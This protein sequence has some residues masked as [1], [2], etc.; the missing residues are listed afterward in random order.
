MA[1]AL[2]PDRRS[3]TSPAHAIEI[4]R[5]R[6]CRSPYRR[7]APR[8][9]VGRGVDS[10]AGDRRL[11]ASRRSRDA[12]PGAPAARSPGRRPSVRRRGRTAL[13]AR[14]AREPT[15]R[16]ALRRRVPAAERR[17]LATRTFSRSRGRD[18]DAARAR[19]RYLVD[20]SSSYT[21]VSKIKPCTCEYDLGH[22]ERNYRWLIKSVVS[23][24]IVSYPWI[25][26]VI[27]E[28]IHAP[29]SPARVRRR[30]R[31]GGGA[32]RERFY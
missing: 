22:A 7:D 24:E 11:S 12:R 10:R 14:R 9:S 13:A 2:H 16:A 30:P 25:S 28:L 19:T 15:R 17:A 29:S 31:A 20:P 27:L 23:P 26:V 4:T 3:E 1:L 6:A 5:A 32:R 8:L 21:L 18:S